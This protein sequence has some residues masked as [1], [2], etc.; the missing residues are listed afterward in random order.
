VFVG[1]ADSWLAEAGTKPSVEDIAANLAQ[2]VAS[3]PYVIPAALVDEIAQT[4]GM[5]DFALG[6]TRPA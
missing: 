2:I 4:C 1:L 6:P 3:D 5:R